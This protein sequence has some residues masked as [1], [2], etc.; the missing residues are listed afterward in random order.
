MLQNKILKQAW[1][2][3]VEPQNKPEKTQ[4]G[5]F[6]NMENVWCSGLAFLLDF[7]CSAPHKNCF[8][9]QSKFRLFEAFS[10]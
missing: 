8:F 10:P 2:S 3:S 1:P 5:F 6:I 9:L 4:N 7:G